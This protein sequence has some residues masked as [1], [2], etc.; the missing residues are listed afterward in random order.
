[1]ML[2]IFTSLYILYMDFSIANNIDE[3]REKIKFYDRKSIEIK[4]KLKKLEEEN[5]KHENNIL[6]GFIFKRKEEEKEKIEEIKENPEEDQ[7]KDE[8]H[9]SIS[10]KDRIKRENLYLKQKILYQSTRCFDKQK[11]FQN[12]RNSFLKEMVGKVSDNSLFIY[13]NYSGRNFHCITC[14]NMLMK[15]CSVR[16]CPKGHE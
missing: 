8:K 7:R 11:N 1:M 14:S 5:K 4:E 6:K 12:L 15:G 9:N 3:T 2:I 13:K 10:I 16:R